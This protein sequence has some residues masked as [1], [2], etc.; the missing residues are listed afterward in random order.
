MSDKKEYD[1]GGIVKQSHCIADEFPDTKKSCKSSDAFTIYEHDSEDGNNVWYDAWCWSCCQNF[2]M[3]QVH[4]ST[5]AKELGV[6]DS[7]VVVNRVKMSRAVK[8]EPL[9]RQE[10]LKLIG[11]IGYVSHNYRSIK[12][13]YS[14]FFGHLSKLNSEGAVIAQYYPETSDGK[15]TGYKP[16]WHPKKFGT[17]LGRTGIKSDLSGQSKFRD[18]KGHRNILIVGGEVD[19]VSAYQML[20]EYQISK[21]QADYAPVAVVSPTTGEGSAFLQIKDQ[22]DFL[23]GFENIII[24]FDND[25]AGRVATEKCI[26][27]LPKDK[28]KIV[29]WT[30][31]D[32][33]NALQLGNERQWL[34]DYFGAKDH[35]ASSI[36]KS[37]E[38]DECLIEELSIQKTPIAQYMHKLQEC[39]AGGIPQGVIVNIVGVT[40]GGK[41]THTNELL[42]YWIFNS[43]ALMGVM[44]LELSKG[45]YAIA[46]LSRHVGKK[47]QMFKT[48]EE[49]IAFINQPDIKEKRDELWTNEYGEDRFFLLDERDNNIE[50]VKFKCETL[51]RKYGCRLI[52]LDPLQDLIGSLTNEKQEEFM[53]WQ[54]NF[55][56]NGVSFI[57]V[58]HTNKTDSSSRG[59]DK[60]LR[61]LEDDDIKGT[62]AIAASGDAN[63]FI[64]RDKYDPCTIKRN[65][66]WVKGVIRWSGFSG[67]CGKWYYDPE[68]HTTYDFD[69]YFDKYPEKLPAGFDRD[70]TPFE[71]KKETRGKPFKSNSLNFPS[72]ADFVEL[73]NGVKL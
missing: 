56:K 12:D 47:I 71:K 67:R 46:V 57:N 31:K 4:T 37:S 27:V 49:S 17:P 68:T 19:K 39:M 51:F 43:P 59:S 54:K 29:T 9:T 38:L 58:N 22:Y 66:T 70:A 72:V 28:V 5:H 21:R 73:E 33:N 6:G 42:Y 15:L 23:N 44:S 20:R 10:A 48:P 13:E 36:I 14:Q 53:A 35:V 11:D 69:D 61:D 40:K 16:R 45:Q 63:I 32:P 65:T 41:T 18:Y 25:E 62:S 24:G 30:D 50:Q 52:V 8:A 64:T 55:K 34:S 7:G 2:S 60:P 26:E 1:K 3:E